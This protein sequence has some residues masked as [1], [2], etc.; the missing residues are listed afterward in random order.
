MK[1]YLSHAVELFLQP[2]EFFKQ[3]KT[4]LPLIPSVSSISGMS[5]TQV[6][7]NFSTSVPSN[8]LLPHPS[9]NYEEIQCPKP[10]F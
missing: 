6:I 7:E 4:L 3:Q 8:N 5:H 1:W 2:W 10:K 9:Y